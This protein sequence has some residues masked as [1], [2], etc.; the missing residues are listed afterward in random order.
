MNKWPALKYETLEWTNTQDIQYLSRKSKSKILSTYES[1]IPNLISPMNIT[2]PPDLESSISDLMI[3]IAR[4]DA[5]QETKGYEFPSML[6][7]SESAASSQ[8]ENLTSSIR[9][10]AL[11]EL[12][13]KSPSNAKLIADNV[14]SM[15]TALDTQETLSLDTI[16]NIHRALLSTSNKE[17][18]GR[19]REQPV[20][21]GGTNYS[22]HEAIF[23]PVHHSRLN[24]Y[25]N[26]L[27]NYS[28]RIDVNPIVKTAI[29]HAQFETIHPFID[30]NG[31]TGR[32]IL[33]KT[34]KD[35]GVLQ[36]VTLPIS[37]G[38]LNNTESYMD[39][40]L[41]YQEGD[42][43]P[44]IEEISSALEL[45]VMIGNETSNQ[46]SKV[47]E[48][49]ES[50]IQERK[51]SSIWKLLYL[52]IEQ[53]VVDTSY[54]EDRL[55]ITNRGANKLI[56][57]AQEYGILRKLGNAHRGVFYQSDDIINVMESVSDLSILQRNP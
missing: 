46:I 19:F 47:I 44:I 16:L 18:A 3:N 40:L 31:R 8:I 25:L 39:A 34:L 43:I 50:M 14:S 26:D 21:I 53:P 45:A 38:L 49:W 29:I 36:T 32:T 51:N 41:K 57:R 23:T 37:A 56:I 33:H 10:I 35:D 11:A 6:L 9:N 28:K 22:P 52:L 4:F 12:S 5:R 54:I 24:H 48:H 30:G 27:I 13:D 15:H 55:N 17:F 42:P 7:R 1:S 2:L 20:W